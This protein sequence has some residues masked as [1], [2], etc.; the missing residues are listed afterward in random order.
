MKSPVDRKTVD[1]TAYPDLVVIYRLEAIA[2]GM[3]HGLSVERITPHPEVDIEEIDRHLAAYTR[4]D[5][6]TESGAAECR[7]AAG[8]P[9][10]HLWPLVTA[11]GGLYHLSFQ[12]FLAAVRLRFIPVHL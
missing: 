7:R 4:S 8:R 10:V 2:L 12:E 11:K 1:L 9:L 6:V 5:V 3:H